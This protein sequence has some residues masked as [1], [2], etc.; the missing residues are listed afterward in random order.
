MS[1]YTLRSDRLLPIDGSI[2]LLANANDFGEVVVNHRSAYMYAAKYARHFVWRLNHLYPRIDDMIPFGDRG[3]EQ[4]NRDLFDGNHEDHFAFISHYK[5]G[6]GT[7]A[8]LL[9]DEL[10]HELAQIFNRPSNNVRAPIFVD[11]EDLTDLSRLAKSN[12][13]ADYRQ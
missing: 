1:R 3:I 7:I 10:Q 12:I 8:S 9:C 5:V 2:I 11:S 4:L 6:A 13:L